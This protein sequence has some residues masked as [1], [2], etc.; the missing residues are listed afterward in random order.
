MIMST[1]RVAQKNWRIC[2]SGVASAPAIKHQELTTVE[3]VEGSRQVL[4]SNK[5]NAIATY[6]T[7]GTALSICDES[8]EFRPLV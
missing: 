8:E 4:F 6:P 7:S 5:F 1:C 2:C 3:N